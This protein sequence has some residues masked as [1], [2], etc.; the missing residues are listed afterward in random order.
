MIKP[1]LYHRFEE[2]ELQED[3]KYCY[4]E[5]RVRSQ[6]IANIFSNPPLKKKRIRIHSV[7]IKSTLK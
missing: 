6:G 7:K 3:G 2:K 1:I 5:K 4:G